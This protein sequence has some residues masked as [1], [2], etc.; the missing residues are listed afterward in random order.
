MESRVKQFNLK[1]L[2]MPSDKQIDEGMEKL[3]C[4]IGW[5]KDPVVSPAVT[6]SDSPS[7]LTLTEDERMY[8][9]CVLDNPFRRAGWYP[10]RLGTSRRKTVAIRKSLNEK[11]FLVDWPMDGVR[12]GKVVTHIVR[13]LE[14]GKARPPGSNG[15]TGSEGHDKG[16]DGMM[17]SYT[18]L[19]WSAEREKSFA[20]GNERT[21]VDIFATDPSGKSLC[22]ELE[23]CA[24]NATTNVRKDLLAGNGDVLVVTAT[25]K[26][27]REIQRD[28]SKALKKEELEHVSFSLLSSF[29]MDD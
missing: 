11:G 13:P 4:V 22:A 10:R 17:N 20:V 15:R 7:I 9:D 14:D 12:G 26:V 25:R 5:E 18:S 28:L 23:M 6:E 19:G 27:A 8:Y 21:F 3:K 1:H 2:V 16:L 24:D 29:L